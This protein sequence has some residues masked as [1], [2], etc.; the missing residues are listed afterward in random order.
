MASQHNTIPFLFLAK[1]P[2]YSTNTGVQKV[3]YNHESRNVSEA[4]VK[5]QK[6]TCAHTEQYQ[7]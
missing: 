4:H 6:H 3:Y 1:G 5:Q 2:Q 7:R